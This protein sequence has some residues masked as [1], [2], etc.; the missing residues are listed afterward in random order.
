MISLDDEDA[1]RAADPSGLLD[2]FLSLPAQI[3]PAFELGAGLALDPDQPTSVALCGM[4]GSGAAADVV[5]ALIATHATVPVSVVKGRSLPAHVGKEAICVCLSYSGGTEEALSCY[6][7]A[8]ARGSIL[9]ALASGGE[10]AAT[11]REDGALVELP[12]AASMPRA[13]LGSLVGGLLG[14]VQATGVDRIDRDDLEMAIQ[15]LRDLA[16][17]IEPAVPI[18]RN[19][20]KQ[21]AAWLGDRMPVIWGSQGPAEAAA[22]R[23][24][25]AFNE[26]AKVP[27]FSSALPEMTHHEVVG[28]A[29]GRGAGFA[30]VALRH[31]DEHPATED[32]LAAVTDVVASSGLEVRTVTARGRTMLSRLLALI[33][34][35]DLASAY[36]A[37]IRGI[38]PTPIHAIASIK[39]RLR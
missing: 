18:A 20:A 34:L 1:L 3:V 5:G 24:K 19:E 4:G 7:E 21:I 11:A 39:D 38:D 31:R 2:A 27:A 10:L 29:K 25:A 14:V 35:G 33:L 37:L 32:L 23:W 28:W 13:A 30:A 16:V 22:S 15:D 17:A 12:E 6:R 9:V 8:R 26:N 36:H